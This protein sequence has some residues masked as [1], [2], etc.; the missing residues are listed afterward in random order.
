MTTLSNLQNQA[1]NFTKKNGFPHHKHE[2]WQYLSLKKL[3]ADLVRSSAQPLEPNINKISLSNRVITIQPDGFSANFSLPKGLELISFNNLK[4]EELKRYSKVFL[5]EKGSYL[6]QLNFG[7]SLEP[8]LIRVQKKQ[9]IEDV[10]GIDLIAKESRDFPRIYFDLQDGSSSNFVFQSVFSGFQNIVIDASLGKNT[11]ASFL[12]LS[13]AR[14]ES[15]NLDLFQ[16]HQDRDSRFNFYGFSAGSQLSKL[17][18]E[19]HLNAP[20][21]S[22]NLNGI[23]FL[24]KKLEQHN[25][26]RVFHNVPNCESTQVFR[27][28]LNDTAKASF[29]GMV[30]VGEGAFGTNADQNNKNLLIS[31]TANAHTKPGLKIYNDDVKCTHGA[32]IGQLD[33]QQIFYLRSRGLREKEAKGLLTR[34]FVMDLLNN[35]PLNSFKE[36]VISIFDETNL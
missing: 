13:E 14:P 22:C 5:N 19:V 35:Y 6:S 11:Q 24:N 17:E 7:Q 26:T 32:T 8:I 36:K 34:A 12:N 28:V 2:D 18:I 33:D 27:H 30:T 10:I 20:G 21:S 25:L 4:E 3:P 23:A 16:I 9:L 15:Q 31:K 29:S 1:Y